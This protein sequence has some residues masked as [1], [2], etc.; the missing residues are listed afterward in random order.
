MSTTGKVLSVLILLSSLLWMILTAGV[1]QMNRN[2]NEAILLANSRQWPISRS[3]DKMG[4]RGRQN[5]G[6]WTTQAN[7]PTVSASEQETG[8]SPGAAW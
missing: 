7:S 6:L 2:G 5:P 3:L 1:A 4:D 8:V